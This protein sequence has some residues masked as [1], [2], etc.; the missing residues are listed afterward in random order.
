MNLQKYSRRLLMRS[1]LQSVNKKAEAHREGFQTVAKIAALWKLSD[2][3]LSVLLGLSSEDQLTELKVASSGGNG[4]EFLNEDALLRISQLL[5][6]FKCLE[7]LFKNSN[8]ADT[9]LSSPNDNHFFNGKPPIE[10]M[11]SDY[12]GIER[13]RGYLEHQCA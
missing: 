2:H 6:I 10:V 5:G 3:Q 12:N 13:V 8:S 1:D 7:T 9:W 11:L 4:S